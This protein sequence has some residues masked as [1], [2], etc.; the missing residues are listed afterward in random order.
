MW[1]HCFILHASTCRFYAHPYFCFRPAT[2]SLY[3][4]TCGFNTLAIAAVIGS[5]YVPAT[6]SVAAVATTHGIAPV[7][8]ILP[9]T[10]IYVID[11]VLA[12]ALT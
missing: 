6:A 10:A 7:A 4:F 3:G 8:D 1:Y 2:P 9:T 12:S 11:T 5:P